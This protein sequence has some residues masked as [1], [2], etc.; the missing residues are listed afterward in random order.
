MA[1]LETIMMRWGVSP[2]RARIVLLGLP[3]WGFRLSEDRAKLIA[4]EHEQA[5]TAVVRHMFGVRGL[6]VR[7]I[8]DELSAMG[9]TG[10][11]GKPLTQT[12]IF[13][14]VRAGPQSKARAGRPRKHR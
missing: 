13:E 9:V 6:S 7:A 1:S 3:P 14:M 2:D 4:D 8:V 12:R 5:I 10:R 11:A